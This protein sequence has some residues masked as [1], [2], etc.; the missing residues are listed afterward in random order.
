M[1]RPSVGKFQSVTEQVRLS[2]ELADSFRA[3]CDDLQQPR[4]AVLRRLIAK[5]VRQQRALTRVRGKA[6]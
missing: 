4:S 6:S 3:T 2:G 5:W 1:A